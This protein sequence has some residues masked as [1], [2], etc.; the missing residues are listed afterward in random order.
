M[1][2]PTT[3]VHHEHNSRCIG[4]IPAHTPLKI[5]QIEQ[6]PFFQDPWILVSVCIFYQLTSCCKDSTTMNLPTLQLDNE[7]KSC[8]LHCAT[9]H[10]VRTKKHSSDHPPSKWMDDVWNLDE[11]A[12]WYQQ[13]KELQ[14]QKQLLCR[15]NF[16]ILTKKWFSPINT[17]DVELGL[18]S[19]TLQKSR[20]LGFTDH[21]LCREL[22][23][24]S[25]QFAMWEMN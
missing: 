16:Q 10:E 14:D 24:S 23:T 15:F 19:K 20:A 17:F 11:Q 8:C 21:I 6:N 2:Y 18:V 13:P 3:W 25:L 7:C 9:L 4:S 12:R 22:K 1:A 5:L